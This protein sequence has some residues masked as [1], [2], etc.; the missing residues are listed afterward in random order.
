MPRC[1]GPALGS[2]FCPP[3]PPVQRPAKQ[4][5]RQE[6]S[7]GQVERPGGRQPPC[8]SHPARRGQGPEAAAGSPWPSQASACT[9]DGG[10]GSIPP[11]SAPAERRHEAA[12]GL[13]APPH[14]AAAGPAP[15]AHLPRLCNQAGTAHPFPYRVSWLTVEA[16]AG[17]SGRAGAGMVPRGS[18][19]ECEAP[20]TLTGFRS[21]MEP[22]CGPGL[23]G[24]PGAAILG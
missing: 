21:P 6:P 1:Q 24:G 7:P 22:W 2:C 19:P 23:R 3:G 9:H 17:A 11:I 5:D 10:Q 18:P 8:S 20:L 14:R 16:A 4:R 12:V 13:G 15:P